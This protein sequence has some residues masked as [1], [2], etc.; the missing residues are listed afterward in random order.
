MTSPAGD[1]AA[2]LVAAA[3]AAAAPQPAA[4]AALPA[5]VPIGVPMPRQSLEV[6]RGMRPPAVAALCTADALVAL[7]GAAHSDGDRGGGGGSAHAAPPP[8]KRPRSSL[9]AAAAPA[10]SVGGA[11]GASALVAS[12]ASPPCDQ[13]DDDDADAGTAP[14]ADGDDA[15]E[16]ARDYI[17]VSDAPLRLV[18]FLHPFAGSFAMTPS[19]LMHLP[20]PLRRNRRM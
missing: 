18:R 8:T 7:A 2:V 9:A 17:C 5:E 15:G 6:T 1:A 14:E 10:S 16:G 12:A 13:M 4:A 3:A 11:A 20:L 19:F